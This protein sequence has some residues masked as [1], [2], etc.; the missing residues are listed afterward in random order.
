MAS[1]QSTEVYSDS[2]CT[3]VVS[4]T[5]LVNQTCSSLPC[6]SAPSF[7]NNK[8]YYT[9]IRC[10]SDG[11]YEHVQHIFGTNEYVLVDMY[12]GSHCNTYVES[13]AVAASG[14]CELAGTY[15]QSVVATLFSNGS[16]HLAYFLDPSCTI[17]SVLYV[18]SGE[19][20]TS[21]KCTE[22]MRYYSSVKGAQTNGVVSSLPTESPPATSTGRKGSS[23]STAVIAEIV[24]AI[25]LVVAFI[26][27]LVYKKR[28]LRRNS[29]EERSSCH[30][31]DHR[32][33]YEAQNS[34][35][36]LRSQ[37]TTAVSDFDQPSSI[38]DD[39]VIVGA[40][41]PR[42]KVTIDKIISRGGY[43][44]VYLGSY[45]NKPVAVKM[46]LP[47]KQRTMSEVSAFLSE[48]KLMASLDH[49]HIVSFIGVAWDQ[50]IDIC[51]LSE[52]MAGGDL[53][54]YLTEIEHQEHPIGFDHTKVTIALHVSM[55]LTYLHSF[56]PPVIHRDLKSK[57]IL[58][59]EELNAKVTDFGI[60][61]ERIDA[62]M[63]GGIGTSFW[64][65]P[66]VMMGERYDDKVDMFSFGVVL[67][68][69]DSHVSPYAES[70]S[71]HSQSKRNKLPSAAIMQMVAAGKMCV[72]FS[73]AT[74][75]S[76]VELGLA[77]VALDPKERP[78]AVE[79]LYRLQHILDEEF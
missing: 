41:I 76:L 42:E 38:W 32:D 11:I 2:S 17:P 52:Y 51:V 13:T 30:T 68:E 19:D 69:L 28:H 25:L 48:V 27:L 3:S 37:A 23:L 58:L 75:R 46:L 43:G 34:P 12:R 78:T 9:A 71:S 57:N 73:E 50:L 64:M 47:E 6:T 4:L 33:T 8:N 62:T 16:A 66:E 20:I 60:S 10:P 5:I 77:C 72:T 49:P 55:A 65:A 63:T 39:D 14:K 59:D 53:K 1:I 61:R 22:N 7:P 44:E 40:R 31:Y 36:K 67:S 35:T 45:Y 15:G 24:A 18:I 21:H 54:A 56:S 70:R 74:P 26:A 29:N 79:A